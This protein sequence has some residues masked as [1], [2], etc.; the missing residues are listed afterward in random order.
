MNKFELL[1]A[2]AYQP[3]LYRL[4]ASTAVPEIKWQCNGQIGGLPIWM[5]A[6]LQTRRTF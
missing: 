6:P 5:A 3:G 1:T 4:F 2:G